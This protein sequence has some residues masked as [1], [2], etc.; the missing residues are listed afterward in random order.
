M[1]PVRLTRRHFLAATAAP[2][3]AGQL[4]GGAHVRAQLAPDLVRFS[5]ET[6]PLV[7]LIVATPRERCVEVLAEQFRQGLPYRHF[8]AALYLTAIRAAPYHGA[9]HGFDHN[10]YSIYSAHQLALDLP[11]G[12]MLL[13]ALWALD[14][15]KAGSPRHAEPAVSL[16][17]P[18]PAA[19][20]VEDE[21]DTGI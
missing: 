15:L 2:T 19:D 11:P 12:E 10:A 13:P 6:E 21:L 17:G 7:K 9:P 14:S 16:R 1:T 20:R 4:F 8:L 18:L 5:P 3:I